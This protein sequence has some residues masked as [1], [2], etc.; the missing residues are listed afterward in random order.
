MTG[1]GSERGQAAAI[2]SR[3]K[4]WRI[5]RFELCCELCTLFPWP[6]PS[7]KGA[8]FA[9]SL[10]CKARALCAEYRSELQSPCSACGVLA[11]LGITGLANCRARVLRMDWMHRTKSAPFEAGKRT[12]CS[13]AACRTR[14]LQFAESRIKTSAHPVRRALTSRHG[15]ARAPCP[16]ISR[17]SGHPNLAASHSFRG[18]FGRRS[19]AMG[20]VRAQGIGFA[21]LGPP[22]PAPNTTAPSPHVMRGTGCHGSRMPA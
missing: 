6:L 5:R 21:A 13:K 7:A 4:F 18:R 3:D 9:A 2:S 20:G 15:P 1:Q 10:S 8:E 14:A 11:K 22:L 16:A 17:L 19:S 12:L